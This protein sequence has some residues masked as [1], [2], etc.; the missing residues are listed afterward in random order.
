[1]SLF[2]DSDLLIVLLHLSLCLDSLTLTL[3]LPFFSVCL[4][5]LI[6]HPSPFFSTCLFVCSLYLSKIALYVHICLSSS[7]L[8]YLSYLSV[9]LVVFFL[10]PCLFLCLPFFTVYPLVRILFHIFVFFVFICIYGTKRPMFTFL[11]FLLIHL[12]SVIFLLFMSVCLSSTFFIFLLHPACCR[13]DPTFYFLFFFFFLF[14][15]KEHVFYS[16]VCLLVVRQKMF[17]FPLYYC[18]H[19]TF[20]NLLFFHI[21]PLFEACLLV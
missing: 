19:P 4:F 10:S 15:I 17:L 6:L 12:Y 5:V 8:I 20:F 3:P 7:S 14:L 18:F 11:F 1:M 13:N 2:L 21:S 16:F 9:F